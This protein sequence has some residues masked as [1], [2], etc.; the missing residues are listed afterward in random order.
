VSGLASSPEDLE[1]LL[2]DALVLRDSVAAA[3]LFEDGGVLVQLSGDV[4][5]P[6]HVARLLAER[7][8]VASPS[9]VTV[10]R[11]IAVVVGPE[12]VNISRQDPRGGWRLV[13]AILTSAPP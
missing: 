7:G 1:L 8:Y 9:S 2:E 6:S 13:A 4:C 11:D 5:G 3:A 12:T 10:I